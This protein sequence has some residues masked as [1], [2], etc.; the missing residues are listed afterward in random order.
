ML[1]LGFL[2]CAPASAQTLLAPAQPAWVTAG[3]T[4]R[5]RVGGP[6]GKSPRLVLSSG[7][8]SPMREVASGEYEALTRAPGPGSTLPLKVDWGEGPREVGTVRVLGG[9]T[10]AARVRTA[11]AVYRSGPHEDFDRYDPLLAGLVVQVTGRQGEWVRIHPGGGWVAAADLELLPAGT[12]ISR[13]VL[14]TASIAETADGLAVLTLRLG[15]PAPW[16]VETDPYQHRLVLHLPGASV[17]MGEV[18][19]PPHSRRVEL[20]ELRP[21]PEGL[22]VELDLG[23]EGLWGYSLEWRAPDLRLRLA[24]PPEAGWTNPLPPGSPASIAAPLRGLRVVVDPGHGGGDTGAVGVGGLE[25]KDLNLRVSLAL[26]EEL[27]AAGAIVT[28]TRREDREVAS[29]DAPAAQEL[30]ARVRLAEAAGGQLFLSV[31]HNARPTI[32]EARIAHGTDIYYYHPQSAPLARALAEPIARS[33]G[34]PDY[35]VLWRSF[36]VIRQTS[37]LAV[38]LELNYLSN[39]QVEAGMLT[40]ADYPVS[41]SRAIREGLEAFLRQSAAAGR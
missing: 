8:S 40:R 28:V 7:A 37:M 3:E 11:E 13:P 41:V 31:H 6:P 23:E 25:E 26:Q 18:A 32:E 34:E 22:R 39:P 19:Y 17:A 4:V 38:L 33:M 24:A 16:Q 35:R 21:G 12:A 15:D 27:E 10:E 1:A 2:L 14:R 9:E 30:G 5:V 20:L 36:F 29:P